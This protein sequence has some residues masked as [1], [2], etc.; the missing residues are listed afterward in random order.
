MNKS[1][2]NKLFSSIFLILILLFSLTSCNFL[3]NPEDKVQVGISWSTDTVDENSKDKVDEDTQ[4]YADAVRKAGGN[5]V[6]LPKLKSQDDAIDNIDKVDVVIVTG[7]DD[8]NPELY[9]EEPNPNLEDI[10]PPRDESDIYLIKACLEKDKPTLGTCR[11]MQLTNILS[12]G[13]LYQDIIS[14]RP[15]EI[16]H[17]DPNRE[18][19]VK[20]EVTISEGNI[21][22]EV[23][24]TSGEIE[25]NSWHHQAIKDLGENLSVLATAPDGTIEAIARSDKTFFLGVQWHPEE[26]I[27]NDNNQ[28]ALK[29][30]QNFFKTVGKPSNKW[31]QLNS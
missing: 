28:E 25:I 8:I 31:T 26:L 7:G 3:D 15:T 6:F 27:V 19:Y 9:G 11:G 4:M 2:I 18:I 23:M 29:L 16:A 1:K 17:R 22:S 20:H 24:E 10:N 21:L 12:G 5:P 14:Q 13:A 30:Y